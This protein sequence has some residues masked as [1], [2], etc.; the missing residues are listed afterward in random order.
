MFLAVGV[1]QYLGWGVLPFE[2]F[3]N[4]FCAMLLANI[5]LFLIKVHHLYV[6]S[7][8]KC[9]ILSTFWRFWK[10]FEVLHINSVTSDTKNAL[11][12]DLF[13]DA[14]STYTLVAKTSNLSFSI[15]LG[16]FL[17]QI[18]NFDLILNSSGIVSASMKGWWTWGHANT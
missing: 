17:L 12:T 6:R 8:E 9:Y 16:Q 5:P 13:E 4:F 7:C 15:A 10:F 18:Q 3:L 2:N 14:C 11:P 1:N